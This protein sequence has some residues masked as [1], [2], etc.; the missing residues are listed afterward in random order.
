MNKKRKEIRIPTTVQLM[1]ISGRLTG[2]ERLALFSTEIYGMGIK[3]KKQED[4]DRISV[5]I[6]EARGNIEACKIGN[7]FKHNHLTN[8]KNM[9]NSTEH[10]LNGLQKLFVGNGCKTLALDS[11]MRFNDT[12][13]DLSL[14]EI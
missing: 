9:I 6:D 14:S 11:N 8:L 5:Y 13:E 1:E 3:A 7:S 10:N 4:F 2:I 12:K